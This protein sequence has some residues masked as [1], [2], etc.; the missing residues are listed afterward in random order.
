MLKALL[1]ALLEPIET[2]R[3]MESAGD[4]TGRL[5][6]QEDLK[7]LPWG[8]VWDYHCLRSETPAGSGWLEEIRRYERDVLSQ[9]GS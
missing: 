2:L 3:E 1:L 7:T 6:L 5:A 8:S 9:R 4:F